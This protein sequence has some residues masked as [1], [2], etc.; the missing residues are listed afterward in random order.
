MVTLINYYIYNIYLQICFN[1]IYESF[2]MLL[3]EK[4]MFA[5][6]IKKS[7]MICLV[8]IYINQREVNDVHLI[9]FIQQTENQSLIIFFSLKK[10]HI[11]KIFEP[12]IF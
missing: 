5:E 8:F 2:K 9:K 7:W 12:L 1:N 10:L 4:E 3:I 6:R 11:E